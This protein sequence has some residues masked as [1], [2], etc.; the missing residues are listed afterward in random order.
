MTLGR[1]AGI[2]LALAMVAS[3]AG[4]ATPSFHD[5]DI[6]FRDGLLVGTDTLTPYRGDMH[7]HTA[8][9]DGEETPETAYQQ[10]QTEGWLDFFA[11]T[12]HSEWYLFPFRAD[13]DCIGIQ[14]LDCYE[15]PTPERTEWEETGHQAQ[16]FTD[17]DFLAVR[18][19]EWS[20][21][22]EGH[23]NVYDT[24]IWTDAQQTGHA[25]MTGLYGWMAAEQLDEDRYATFNHP[26]REPLGFDNFSYEPRMD[27]YFVGI[28]AFNRDDDYSDHYPE[29]LDK[30]WHLGAHGVTD[31]H[32][33]DARLDRAAGHTVALMHEFTKDG[34]REAF[35][36]H[37]T[38]ATRG[39]DQDA[40]LWV[41]DTLMGDVLT[42]PGGTVE[43]DLVLFDAGDV[44]ATAF[45][46]AELLGP[47]GFQQDLAIGDGEP[48]DR[49]DDGQRQ[50][51]DCE[52]TVD[53]TD[54]GTTDLGEKYI[55]ARAY[56]D[57]EQ[58]GSSEPTVVTSAVW[59]DGT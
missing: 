41:D 54:M 32:D 2:L 1:R 30:G 39:S 52:A 57:Y 58:D 12:E 42:D 53:L 33:A 16:R 10:A 46:R 21:Q 34:L 37:H 27:P 43:V 31:G 47:D 5:D 50:W 8:Y 45:D 7:A 13:F 49:F 38:V 29:A 15:S 3:T 28:E 35:I 23:V 14:A 25:P 19:F 59:I 11:V 55:T 17:E 40:R 9:S 18:G 44:G 4:A 56:Q 22:I 6:G 20:S 36:Q 26:W 48:C 51:I 24:R